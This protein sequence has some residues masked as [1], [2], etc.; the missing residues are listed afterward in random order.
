MAVVKPVP[1]FAACPGTTCPDG[2]ARI[3][4]RIKPEPETSPEA[5]PRYEPLDVPAWLPFWLGC[6]LAGSVL[7]VLIVI[8]IGYPLAVHQQSRGPLQAL[9]PAPRLETAPV[10]QLQR[11]DAAKHQELES[12][13]DAAMRATAQQGW[14]PPK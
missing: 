10:R 5:P 14:G 3:A 13:I 8:T 4:G 9:P 7:A 6:L 12:R 11:Y 1:G 2:E